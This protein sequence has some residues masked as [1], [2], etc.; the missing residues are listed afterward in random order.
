MNIITIPYGKKKIKL[1][2]PTSFK[3]NI[4]NIKSLAPIKNFKSALNKVLNKPIDNKSFNDS[5]CPQDHV[6]ISIPDKTRRGY[7]PPI[8][9]VILKRLAVCGVPDDHIVILIARGSHFSHTVKELKELVGVNTYKKFKIIDHDCHNDKELSYLGETSRGTKV[10]LNSE[11]LKADKIITCGVIQYHYFAGFSGGRKLIIPGCAA[12]DSII[13]N[14]RLALNTEPEKGRNPDATLG[15]LSGNPVH[16]DILEA[17]YML[18]VKGKKIFSID[19]VLNDK[20]QAAKIFCGDIIKTHEKGCKLVE[21]TYSVAIKK[22]A[23]FIIA[24]TGGFPSDINFIQAHKTLEQA[25]EGLKENGILFAFAECS[26]GIGSDTFL[27]WFKYPTAYELE[28]ALRKDFLINGHTALATFMKANKFQIYLYSA[29][30]PETVRR[31]HLNPVKDPQ[32]TLNRIL[33]S[34]PPKANILFIPQGFNLL[35]KVVNI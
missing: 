20:R 7:F 18:R 31:I 17:I 1:K 22:P 19:L 26:Q 6:A 15:K 3:Y 33:K 13:K 16:E 21:K 10:R 14:H 9:D 11:I 29:L 27:P 8:L 4:L 12:Y 2:I 23:D 25:C 5:F 30:K 28:D 34:L 32:N 35:P 24:S